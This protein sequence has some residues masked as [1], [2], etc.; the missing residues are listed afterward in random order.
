LPVIVA[1]WLLAG[2]ASVYRGEREPVE[3]LFAQ[4]DPAMLRG[5]GEP[6]ELRGVAGAG[7]AAKAELQAEVDRRRARV[8]QAPEDAQRR[9]RLAVA[10][11]RAGQVEEA[12]RQ[13]EKAVA[14]DPTFAKAYYNLGVCCYE[15]DRLDEAEANWLKAVELDQRQVSAHYNLGVLKHAA[16]ALDQAVHHYRQCLKVAPDHRH[17][18]AQVNLGLALA[19]LK[20]F[21]QARKVW[22][23]TLAQ[24]PLCF[25][26]CYN[27]GVLGQQT[28]DMAGA[29]RLWRRATDIP[30]EQVAR[31]MG[32]E[33]AGRRVRALAFYNLGVAADEAE[34]LRKAIVYFRQAFELD[35]TNP[36]VRQ[37]WRS[38][39]RQRRLGY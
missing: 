2:C 22:E 19:G 26:A 11:K 37:A 17:L 33:V 6:V 25:N 29:T 12:V 30:G 24:E 7:V 3:K 21:G 1:V 13:W 23:E 18:K 39:V 28:G 35:S 14:L 5:R 20:E 9:H 10:L 38:A 27:L 15:L 34:D 8:E 4:V 16:N 36:L 32:D 31:E